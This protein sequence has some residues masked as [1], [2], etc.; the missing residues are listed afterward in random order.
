MTSSDV[1]YDKLTSSRNLT[2]WAVYHR[3]Q[4]LDHNEGFKI[5]CN[6][7]GGFFCWDIHELNKPVHAKYTK[8][9]PTQAKADQEARRAVHKFVTS[10]VDYDDVMEKAWIAQHHWEYLEGTN[11]CSAF[12]NRELDR[13]KQ[14]REQIVQPKTSISCIQ[15]Y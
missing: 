13:V 6:C 14:P 1:L 15:S 11:D 10:K 7:K 12:L 8:Y 3:W 5:A 2:V 4:S 9:N